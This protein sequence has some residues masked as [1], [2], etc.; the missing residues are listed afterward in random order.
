MPRRFG[1]E[2]IFVESSGSVPVGA[3]SFVA[4][5]QDIILAPRKFVAAG[6]GSGTATVKLISGEAFLSVQVP[7]DDT[8]TVDLPDSLELAKSSGI[9][10]NVAGAA[11]QV[12]LYYAKHDES[13]GVT[14]S[15]ARTAAFN[16]SLLE[17]KATRNPGSSL[18]GD[19][20]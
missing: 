3:A 16:A 20:S 11:V 1:N 9:D 15:A 5:V 8:V 2:N 14:K 18:L 17:P 13:P 19:Q 4:G 6:I 10:I 7:T 12:N